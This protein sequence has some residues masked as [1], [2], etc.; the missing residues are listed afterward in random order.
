M[1][2]K[3]IPHRIEEHANFD[4]ADVPAATQVLTYADPLWDAQAGGGGGG[5]PT[6]ASYVVGAAH[7]GLS[8]ELVLGTAVIMAGTE[9][10]IPAA[11]L[12]GRLYFATDTLRVFRDTGAAW[13]QIAGLSLNDMSGDVATAQ[14]E[15]AAVT[16]AKIANIATA[17]ILGR[18]TA[19][20][21]VAEELT[22]TQATTLLDAFTSALK[23]VAPASGGGTTNFLR[24]D[25]TWAAP[26]GG[27]GAPS[28]AQY[29]V[30][31]ADATLT[32]ERIL[33]A[34]EGLRSVD[35]GAGSTI[36]LHHEPITSCMIDGRNIT[37]TNLPAGV[38]EGANAIR[39]AQDLTDANEMRIVVGVGVAG[40]T[41]DLKLQYA[42]DAA[43]T[44]TD[45][46]TNLIDL[47]TTGAKTTAWES[48]PAGAKAVVF[49]RAVAFNGNGVEDPQ[50]RGCHIQF[51]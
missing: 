8:A 16:L 44:W 32:V 40:V 25:G 12:G 14:I 18:T 41:G 45:L 31:A 29:V 36:T 6:D 1:A 42:T 2:I 43:A 11:S 10:A 33:T 35:A 5:A 24:A 17:R 50:I 3:P 23:G 22:G 30:L 9:A 19:G 4:R 48:V 13:V 47:S 7:A 46:T 37:Y 26:A 39:S 15:N 21:G 51:R 27:G 38:T 49:I 34:G 28:D 20:A